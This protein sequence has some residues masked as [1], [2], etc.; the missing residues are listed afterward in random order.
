M[1]KPVPLML[2]A[3][4]ASIKAGSSFMSPTIVAN[5]RAAVVRHG[6]ACSTSS[7]SKKTCWA[8]GATLD[9]SSDSKEPVS[10]A[11][12]TAV[13]AQEAEEI[14]EEEEG[15]DVVKSPAGLSLEGVY[16]RLKLE[17]QGFDD[18]VMGLESKDPKFGVGEAQIRSL[19]IL[20]MDRA[21]HALDIC[22]CSHVSLVACYAR[23]GRIALVASRT[24]LASRLSNVV[25]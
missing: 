19:I 22:S 14:E 3:L 25:Q 18:G 7:P 6:R 13:A 17:T 2:V 4:M 10:S 12:T 24:S 23:H 9:G 15:D 11:D 1:P 21:T 5:T 20:I 8:I 16:K